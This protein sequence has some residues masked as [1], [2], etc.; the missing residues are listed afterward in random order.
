[1]NKNGKMTHQEVC[2]LCRRAFAFGGGRYD[3]R[4]IQF[5]KMMVCDHCYDAN[6]DG[7]VPATYPHLIEHFR[8]IGI[9]PTLNIRGFIEWPNLC[10]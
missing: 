7:I 4:P 9:V 5:W 10:R 3:G 6:H 1:M 8:E 2:F